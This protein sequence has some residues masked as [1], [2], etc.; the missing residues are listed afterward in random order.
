MV[1]WIEAQWPDDPA[2]WLALLSPGR[3]EMVRQRIKDFT[4]SDSFVGEVLCT[5]LTDKCTIIRQRAKLPA[6][7]MQMER[8]FSAIRELRDRLAY[9]SHYAQSHQEALEVCC[10][11]R[12]ILKI[13]Q[14]LLGTVG[15]G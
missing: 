12:R 1:D 9:A 6:S 2:S 13:R 8:D 15:S 3:R 14:H 7:R 10:V 4:N 11:T 5:E